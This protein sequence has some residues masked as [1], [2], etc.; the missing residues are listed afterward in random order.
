MSP[1]EKAAENC[2]KLSRYLDA[3]CASGAPLPAKSDGSIN[4]RAIALGADVEPQVLSATGNPAARE[5]VLNAAA[6]QGMGAP[7]Q[8]REIAGEA[9]AALRG[10]LDQ[11]GQGGRPIP[12]SDGVL[13]LQALALETGF[14]VATFSSPE[15][16]ALL[17]QFAS[18]NHIGLPRF[19]SSADVVFAN[20]RGQESRQAAA[21]GRALAVVEAENAR[22]CRDLAAARAE[23]ATL[24]RRIA[25]GVENGVGL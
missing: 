15:S 19:A 17:A 3:M 5:M 6:K 22:L 12:T 7:R 18:S 16:V 25:H 21:M 20:A 23:N 2:A 11:M 8:H 14:T 4:L 13:D 10:A 1:R 24:R 9:M